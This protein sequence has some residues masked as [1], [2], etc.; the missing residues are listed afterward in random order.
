MDFVSTHNAREFYSRAGWT[1]AFTVV[2]YFINRAEYPG[3]ALTLA[4]V[5][6]LVAAAFAGIGYGLHWLATEGRS[7]VL[8]QILDTLQLQGSERILSLSHDLG[9][10]AAKRLKSGKV[11]SLGDTQSNEAARESAKQAGLGD[12]IRFESAD[13]SAKLSYPDSNFDVVLSS[14]ALTNLNQAKTI[15]E[16]TRVLKPGGQLVLHELGSV[17]IPKELPQVTSVPACLPFSIGG[18][19]LTARK[20]S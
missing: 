3:P 10:E 1:L 17:D 19:I 2:L 7:R 11:I 15:Q 6:T 9:M 12:K 13:L 4:V 8:A 14:R 16:L 5:L 20:P 18:R